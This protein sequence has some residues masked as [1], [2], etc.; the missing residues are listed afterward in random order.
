MKTCPC[1]S[2]LDYEKCCKPFHDGI[3][4]PTALALMRSRY[5]AY[6]LHLIEYIIATTHPTHTDFC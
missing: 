6:A 1:H 3:P 2:S 5:S 4:A